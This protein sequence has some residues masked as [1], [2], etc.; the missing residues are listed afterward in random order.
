LDIVNII[1]CTPKDCGTWTAP[2][3]CVIT[4]LANPMRI[5]KM[6]HFFKGTYLHP[7]LT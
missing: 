4:K 5:M 1:K 7:I 2:M 3:S 6:L